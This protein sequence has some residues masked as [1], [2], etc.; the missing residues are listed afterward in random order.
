MLVPLTTAVHRAIKAEDTPDIR[1]AE[2]IALALLGAEDLPDIVV[3][4]GATWDR[5]DTPCILGRTAI[6]KTRASLPTPSD[7]WL[8]EVVHHGKA[9]AV[10]G[11]YSPDGTEIR[12]FCHVIRFSSATAHEIAQM[13][14]FERIEPKNV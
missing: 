8:E 12:L 2:G 6:E 1:R 14:S 13:V 5:T 7:I 4:E 10:S 9:A 3:A 11:R